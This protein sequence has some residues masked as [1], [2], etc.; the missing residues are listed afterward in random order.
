[1]NLAETLEKVAFETLPGIVPGLEQPATYRKYAGTAYDATK[2]A[3]V[4]TFTDTTGVRVVKIDD[5]IEPVRVGESWIRKRQQMYLIKKEDLPST[6]TDATVLRDKLVVNNVTM[7]ITYVEPLLDAF[8][9]ITTE[10]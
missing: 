4:D 3:T 1:M 7:Q 8:Y 6:V 2:K 9:L 5:K 10:L